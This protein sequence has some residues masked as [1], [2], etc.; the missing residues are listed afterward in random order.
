MFRI[1][2]TECND[3]DYLFKEDN[4]KIQAKRL[5][6]KNI[7]FKVEFD[8]KIRRVTCCESIITIIFGN[9]STMLELDEK[10]P[11][12]LRNTDGELEFYY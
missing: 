2:E 1:D 6:G 8:S 10:E 9:R 7:D 3:L 12:E 11:S 4:T 5:V